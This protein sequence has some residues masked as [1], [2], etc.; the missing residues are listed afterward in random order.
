LGQDRRQKSSRP[1]KSAQRCGA[2]AK[3]DSNRRAWR[4]LTAPFSRIG[5]SGFALLVSSLLSGLATGPGFAD[6]R[7]ANTDRGELCLLELAFTWR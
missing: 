7:A 4:R 1:V 5:L 3:T 6:L 2:S